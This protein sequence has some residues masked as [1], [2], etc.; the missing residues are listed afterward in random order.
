MIP[1]NIVIVVIGNLNTIIFL[2]DSINE[3]RLI[4]DRAQ[5]ITT[6]VVFN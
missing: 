1:S 2:D 5:A 6:E 4:P 3:Y